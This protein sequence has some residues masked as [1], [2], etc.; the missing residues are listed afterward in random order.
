MST[1]MWLIIGIVGQTVFSARFF[2]QWIYS[3]IKRRSMFPLAFWFMSIFGGF[4]LL[5]YA[6]HKRDP[7]FIVAQAGGLLIYLRNLHWR[8]LERKENPR[9]ANQP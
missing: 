4:A 7:V 3:E 2:L 6:I 5:C 9:Q 8:L 1:E